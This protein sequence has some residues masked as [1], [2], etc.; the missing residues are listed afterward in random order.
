VDI[1]G[2]MPWDLMEKQK[3]VILSIWR[4]FYHNSSC[5]IKYLIAYLERTY[6]AEEKTKALE[7]KHFQ[8]AYTRRNAG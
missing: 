2:A 3:Y 1:V 5:H 7:I 6:L 8:G 4:V